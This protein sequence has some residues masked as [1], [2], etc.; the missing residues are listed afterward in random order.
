M[1]L[2]LP[3]VSNVISSFFGVTN[4]IL[5]METIDILETQQSQGFSIRPAPRRVV[6]ALA[7]F[8]ALHGVALPA[9]K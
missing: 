4:Y 5:R 7:A 9:W 2:T 6:V 1:K 8:S 3:T